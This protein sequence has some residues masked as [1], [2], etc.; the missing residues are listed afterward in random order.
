VRRAAHP[1]MKL[2]L[3]VRRPVAVGTLLVLV[4]TAL[5]IT[6]FF[7]GSFYFQGYRGYNALQTGLLFLPVALAT[8]A[9]SAIAGRALARLR[10]RL[11]GTAGLL[12]GGTGMWVAASVD[13]PV[14]MVAAIALAAAGTG[15]V[16]VVASATALG[17]VGPHEAGVASGIVSTFHE[18]GAS[19]G[20]AVVSSIAA[21]S[22]SGASSAG[23]SRGFTAAALVA[24]AA[25]VVTLAVAPGRQA[26]PGS[27]S[28]GGREVGDR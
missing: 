2:N 14:A 3:L 6:V 13:R 22:L 16:F 27:I 11:L 17:Q 18:F 8:M 9:G 10:P 26:P 20:A 7:L 24:A 15:A 5:M 19:L 23:F 28:A 1:L 4:A 21:A 12:I 25:A